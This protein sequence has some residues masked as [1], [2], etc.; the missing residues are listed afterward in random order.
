V[1]NARAFYTTRAAAGATGTRLSLRPLFFEAKDL[2]N[3]GA[4]RREIVDLCHLGC[5]ENEFIRVIPGC[6]SWRRPGINTPGRA[7]GFRARAEPVI[8]RA[9]ARPVGAPRNDGLLFVVLASVFRRDHVQDGQR[10]ASLRQIPSRLTEYFDAC[11]GCAERPEKRRDETPA[12][13]NIEYQ[14]QGLYRRDLR[15]SDPACTR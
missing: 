3:S 7:Y 1:T 15:A 12:E 8:G 2:H 10:C 9:F 5:L 4:S 14:G 13:R 11:Q 6:A